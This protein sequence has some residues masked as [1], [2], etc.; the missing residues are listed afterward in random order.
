MRAGLQWVAGRSTLPATFFIYEVIM[1]RVVRPGEPIKSA[2]TASWF[3]EINK[4]HRPTPN[5]HDLS[6]PENP[7]KVGCVAD[8]GITLSRFDAANIVGPAI[9]YE[10]FDGEAEQYNTVMVKVNDTLTESKW[11][12]V[13]EPILPEGFGRLVV[14]GVTWANFDY[15]SGHTHVDIVGGALT[16]GTSGK[17][18]I[19]SPPEDTGKP[20]LILIRT[21]GESSA[22]KLIVVPTGGLPARSGTTVT[23]IVC[24]VLQIES[25]LIGATGESITVYNPWPVSIPQDYYI[26]ATKE[27]ESNFW[28]AE[29][30]GLLNVRWTSPYLEQT[31]NGST[32][33]VIDT[34]EEC[35]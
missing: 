12:I 3:N 19:L 28:I 6:T 32:Y 5:P 2:I 33:S 20:G 7:V 1:K 27:N 22:T 34:A 21:G 9:P 18:L 10:D 15:T 11:G 30:P 26:L 29:F 8:T 16:S 31:I 23:P 14:L 25:N 4:R 24:N 13:Q 35:P 17:G